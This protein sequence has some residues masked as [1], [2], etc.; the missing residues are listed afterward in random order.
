MGD[1]QES[2]CIGSNELPHSPGIWFVAFL[3]FLGI[4]LDSEYSIITGGMGLSNFDG[5][6]IAE[7]FSYG[8]SG[9]GTAVEANGLGVS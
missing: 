1:H 5:C 7:E 4:K 3:N 2:S 6:L 9:I 8:C